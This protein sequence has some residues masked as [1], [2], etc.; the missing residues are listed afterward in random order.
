VIRMDRI[1]GLSRAHDFVNMAIDTLDLLLP[2][3]GKRDED[4]AA[5]SD[6]LII[7]LNQL[8][9]AIE[10]GAELDVRERIR[11]ESSETL[12]PSSGDIDGSHDTE[13]GHH[14]W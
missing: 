13:D 7:G 12:Y 3:N 10:H 9:D 11:L 2:K 8:A 1:L 14:S 5:I 6:H 4:V